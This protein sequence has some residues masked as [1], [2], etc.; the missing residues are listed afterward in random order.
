MWNSIK[1]IIC[2]IVFKNNMWNS[3]KKI[4]MLEGFLYE[5]VLFL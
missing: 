5:C 1:K 2:G 3:I 4:N